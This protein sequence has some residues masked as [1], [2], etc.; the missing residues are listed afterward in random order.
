MKRVCSNLLALLAL[1]AAALLVPGA[2]H[3]Y[4]GPGSIVSG[5]GALLAAVAAIIAAVFGFLWFPVKRLIRKLRGGAEAEPADAEA[6]ASEDLAG[7]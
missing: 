2:A 4:G 3:G 5:I 6:G 1:C 7:S